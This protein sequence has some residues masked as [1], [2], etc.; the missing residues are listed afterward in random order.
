MIKAVIDVFAPLRPGAPAIV[1]F[2]T[3]LADQECV[4]SYNQKRGEDAGIAVY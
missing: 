1:M 2:Q 3:Q 4:L